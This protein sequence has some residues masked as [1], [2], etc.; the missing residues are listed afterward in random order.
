M[1]LGFLHGRR[2]FITGWLYTAGQLSLSRGT[3]R[4][5]LLLTNHRL[6]R[7]NGILNG[8]FT[9]IL[10]INHQPM[11]ILIIRRQGKM[12]RLYSSIKLKHYA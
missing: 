3:L 2:R 9:R 7:V 12:A 10:E 6:D 5:N 8:T 4:L 1:W 11:P